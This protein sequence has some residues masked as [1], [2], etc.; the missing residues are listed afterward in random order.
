MRQCDEPLTSRGRYRCSVSV[1]GMDFQRIMNTNVN[2]ME[3][4]TKRRNGTTAL[5]Q[6]VLEKEYLAAI[7]YERR[8]SICDEIMSTIR[9]AR[10]LMS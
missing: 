6:K 4:H 2:F 7:C 3:R 5:L 9:K 1:G 10:S 8:P